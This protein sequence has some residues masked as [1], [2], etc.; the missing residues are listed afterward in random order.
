MHHRIPKLLGTHIHHDVV[1]CWHK[2]KACTLNVKVTLV[3]QRSKFET[4]HD[5]IPK[6]LCTHAHHD[7][8]TMAE[9]KTNFAK[10][11]LL[12]FNPFPLVDVF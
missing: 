6:L 9:V 3:G 8:V 10:R 7:E 5:R 4:M 2:T 1:K 11:R 12:S